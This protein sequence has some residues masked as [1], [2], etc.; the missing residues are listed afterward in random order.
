M[1]HNDYAR[2]TADLSKYKQQLQFLEV[3]KKDPV[4]MNNALDSMIDELKDVIRKIE[5]KREP[6]SKY[7]YW[8]VNDAYR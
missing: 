1:A 4:F 5:A 7:G 6:I 3:M 2:L 8:A